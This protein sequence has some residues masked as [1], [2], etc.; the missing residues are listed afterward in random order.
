[1]QA[2]RRHCPDNQGRMERTGV[3]V[4]GEIS[5][6][7]ATALLIKGEWKAYLP[8]YRVSHNKDKIDAL[9]T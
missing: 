6:I 8:P 9:A 1:M 3:K 7:V 4:Y 5:F 2:V